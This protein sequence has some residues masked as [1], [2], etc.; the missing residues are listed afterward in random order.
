M[1]LKTPMKLDQSLQCF[2]ALVVLSMG[3]KHDETLQRTSTI[4]DAQNSHEARIDFQHFLS[5]TNTQDVNNENTDSTM[6]FAL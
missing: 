2:L 6:H 4:N 3:S 1:V 5:T